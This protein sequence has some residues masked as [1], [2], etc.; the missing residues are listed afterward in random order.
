M[1]PATNPFTRQNYGAPPAAQGWLGL[2]LPGRKQ[3]SGIYL[4]S[5]WE[6]A[7]IRGWAPYRLT[8]PSIGNGLWQLDAQDTQQFSATCPVYFCLTGFSTWSSQAAGAQITLYDV[9]AAQWLIHPGGPDL[10]TSLL[11]GSGKRPF[12][13][14]EFLFLDPGDTLL[15]DITNLSATP[16][17]GQVVADGYMPLFP[18]VF[19]HISK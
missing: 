19:E 4:P 9:N 12:W 1:D 6:R 7:K 8:I 16:Q 11:G 5:R 18:G 15:A 17:I 10:L 13:L 2:F 14:K 3:L